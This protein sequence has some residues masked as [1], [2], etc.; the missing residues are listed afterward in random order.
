MQM[1]RGQTCRDEPGSKYHL[2][3]LAYSFK[4]LEILGL[5]GNCQL[6]DIAM[7]QIAKNLGQLISLD[8]SGCFR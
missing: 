1:S 5:G 6:T 3:R 7:A 8:I 4:Q 2:P